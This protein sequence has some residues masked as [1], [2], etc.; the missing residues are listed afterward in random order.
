MASGVQYLTGGGE[1]EVRQWFGVYYGYISVN[2]DPTAKGRVKLR[3]PQVLGNTTSGWALP[4]VAVSFVPQVSTP[5]SVMFVGGDPTQPVWF[6]NFALPIPPPVVIEAGPPVANGTQLGEIWYDSSN[7]MKTYEWNGASWIAYQLGTG[8]VASGIGL[9]EPNITGGTITGAQFIA[10]GTSG[11]FLGYTGSPALGNMNVSVSPVSGVDSKSN[12]YQDG[13]TVYDEGAYLQIHVNSA[14][15]A[16]AVEMVAGAAS[17]TLN[18]AIFGWTPNKGTANEYTAT[19]W[20]GPRSSHDGKGMGI[21]MFSSA[22][23]G[24]GTPAWGDLW[25][26]S[27]IAATWDNNGFHVPGTAYLNQAARQV[28][29]FTG[30]PVISQTGGG[31]T[32]S[33]TSATPVSRAFTIP[34]NDAQNSTVYRVK[35][36][37]FGATGTTAYDLG[38]GIAA[39]GV[40]A[41]FNFETTDLPTSVNFG[42]TA[43]GTVAVTSN[44]S[45]GTAQFNISATITESSAHATSAISTTGSFTAFNQSVNTTGATTIAIVAAVGGTAGSPF[46][47]GMFS[48]CERLGP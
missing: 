14:F 36:S 6:G 42:W 44:G 20:N 2:V 29:G 37:G 34:A 46:I 17:A 43:E 47:A 33:T 10:D 9:T 12:A 27:I 24:S 8:G 35:A 5:V 48:T 15:A 39:F 38:F 23:D 21:S 30:Y 7:G 1:G 22:K 41:S 45:G 4:M 11:E 25:T 28:G 26:E 40:T 31:G 16:P 13:V 18:P 32:A 19:Q 3:V